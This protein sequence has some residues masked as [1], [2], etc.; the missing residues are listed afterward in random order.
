MHVSIRMLEHLAIHI[1]A[2][3]APPL[4]AEGLVGQG[5]Q[6]VGYVEGKNLEAAP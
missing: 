5:L 2:F 3:W 6:D 1:A 4:S